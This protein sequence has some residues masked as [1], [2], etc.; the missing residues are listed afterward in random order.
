MCNVI[1]IDRTITSIKVIIFGGALEHH[2]FK[3]TLNY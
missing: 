1:N 3:G 2:N